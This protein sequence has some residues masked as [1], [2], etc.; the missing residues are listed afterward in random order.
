[1]YEEQVGTIIE[2]VNANNQSELNLI[3]ALFHPPPIDSN[4]LTFKEKSFLISHIDRDLSKQIIEIYMLFGQ[5]NEFMWRYKEIARDY[6]GIRERYASSLMISRA[7][8][9]FYY[10]ERERL[11]DVLKTHLENMIKHHEKIK[12]KTNVVLEN[13]KG[14]LNF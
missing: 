3:E 9:S 5:M 6:E 11:E 7:A 2:N 13:L 12:S 10:T 14:K 8:S 1:M 4:F